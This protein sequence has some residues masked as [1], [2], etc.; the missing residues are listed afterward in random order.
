MLAALTRAVET[1]HPS[2]KGHA[3]RVGRTRNRGRAVA[4]LGGQRLERLRLGAL[5]HDVGKLSLETELSASR[6]H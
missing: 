4:R 2:T 3:G 1:R 6:D 5:I